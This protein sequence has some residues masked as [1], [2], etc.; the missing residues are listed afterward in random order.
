MEAS[1]SFFQAFVFQPGLGA[2]G[3]FLGPVLIDYVSQAF[4]L[5]LAFVT[6]AV[7][8]LMLIPFSQ[9]FFKFQRKEKR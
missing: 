5:R 2:S 1:F 8:G 7:A 4:R 9:R 3:M 6:F